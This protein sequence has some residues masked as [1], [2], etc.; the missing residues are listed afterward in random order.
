MNPRL[1]FIFFPFRFFIDENLYRHRCCI[2]VSSLTVA[3]YIQTTPHLQE[4]FHVFFEKIFE[5]LKYE[6]F[7]VIPFSARVGEYPVSRP[8]APQS[9]AQITPL[10]ERSVP[11]I[12]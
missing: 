12:A 6:T 2:A 11:R 10:F 8:A 4:Q 3:Y 1:F 7:C 9:S 5:I